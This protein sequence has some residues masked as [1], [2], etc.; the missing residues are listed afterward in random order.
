MVKWIYVKCWVPKKILWFS[1]LFFVFSV[2]WWSLEVRIYYG[3][4]PIKT[5]ENIYF[6]VMP[7]VWGTYK[8]VI[9]DLVFDRASSCFSMV[10]LIRIR[11]PSVFNSV[12]L[13]FIDG[14]RRIKLGCK[15]GKWNWIR[16]IALWPQKTWTTFLV[17]C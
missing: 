6:C 7:N 4:Y 17:I 9:A 12:E 1:F 3:G 10:V 11:M 8:C 2:F 14:L 16:N 5:S 13:K 15:L